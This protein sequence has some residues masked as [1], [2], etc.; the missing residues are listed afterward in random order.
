MSEPVFCGDLVYKF[1]RIVGKP[2]FG[3]RFR[4][5]V[6]RYTRVGYGLDVV[7]QSACL[8][9]DPITV[10][11]YGFLFGCRMVGRALGSVMALAWGFGRWVVAWCLSVA[12]PAVAQ[13]GVFFSSDCLWV[14][15]PFL[16]FIM[17]CWFD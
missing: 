14:V 3:D 4:G 10:C 5:I 11:G 2:G 7:R 16:C 8:V 6:K 15:G 17:V 9:L 12:G 13:L 1:K